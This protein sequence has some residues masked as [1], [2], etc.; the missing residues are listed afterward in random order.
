[1]NDRRAT[2]EDFQIDLAAYALSSL[3]SASRAAL[4]EHLRGCP[5]CR[6]I[7]SEYERVTTGYPLSLAQQQPPEGALD[8]LLERAR[9]E[10]TVS[11]PP[12][13]RSMSYLW[14]SFAALAALLLVMLGWN[15]WLQ[16]DTDDDYPLDSSS[17]AFVVPLEGSEEAQNA[18]GHLVLDKDSKN[19]ALV[20]SGLPALSAGRD[21]QLW[22]VHADGTR[23]N[24]GVFHSDE[25][26][27]ITVQ[28]IV[29]SNL[30]DV[31]R[32][33]VTEEPAGGSPGPTGRNVLRGVFSLG[34]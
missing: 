21:Y 34:T 4:E 31:E 5:E 32:V 1:M 7:L 13:Q 30:A 16:F 14:A 25:T 3:D 22:F 20:A 29:P 12:A 24:G 11:P 28:V 9:A 17:I 15:L 23:D 33:G 27:Q 10:A 8:R 18:S 19:G 6:A 26:G 2:H